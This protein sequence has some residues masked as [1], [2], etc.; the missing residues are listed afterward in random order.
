MA[1]EDQLRRDFSAG[2]PNRKWCGDFKQVPIAEG[3]VHLAAVEGLYSRRLVGLALSDTT[4]TAQLADT[5][6]FFATL[7]KE[8]L[9]RR[10][11]RTRAEA[12]R[13]IATWIDSW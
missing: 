12:R 4:P 6:S 10:H 2:A 1:P 8:R 9:N 11:Y 7:Q 5:E 13:D 3:P